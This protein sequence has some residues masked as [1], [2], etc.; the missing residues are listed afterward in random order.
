MPKLPPPKPFTVV[1]GAA[2]LLGTGA[3]DVHAR[4]ARYLESGSPAAHSRILGFSPLQA[5]RDLF[6]SVWGKNGS[7]LDPDGRDGNNGAELD[8]DGSYSDRGAQLDSNG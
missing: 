2:L 7:Q 6:S 1:L 8:P 3:G 5:I 4:P